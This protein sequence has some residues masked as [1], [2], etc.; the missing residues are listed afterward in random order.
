MK[1]GVTYICFGHSLHTGLR[2]NIFDTVWQCTMLHLSPVCTDSVVP[3]IAQPLEVCADSTKHPFSST[4]NL[5]PINYNWPS[6]DSSPAT[7]NWLE[8]IALIRHVTPPWPI[9]KRPQWVQNFC[10]NED[11]SVKIADFLQKICTKIMIR[12]RIVRSVINGNI[13]FSGWL[14]V[15]V[16]N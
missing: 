13:A 5:T 4:L 12:R 14:A 1:T 3:L 8:I 9:I 6:P 15:L 7:A 10:T 11:Y 16:C 2:W